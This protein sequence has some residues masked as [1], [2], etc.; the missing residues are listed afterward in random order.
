MNEVS[1]LD[2]QRLNE[3]FNMSTEPED[4]PLGKLCDAYRE[5]REVIKEHQRREKKYRKGFFPARGLGEKNFA[6]KTQGKVAKCNRHPNG[7][8][9]HTAWADGD[10]IQLNTRGDLNVVYALDE[11]GDAHVFVPRGVTIHPC[12]NSEIDTTRDVERM[13]SNLRSYT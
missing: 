10:W 2:E 1:E 3:T 13:V 6:I 11:N 7:S 4:M 12:Y 9:D 8:S 5:Q